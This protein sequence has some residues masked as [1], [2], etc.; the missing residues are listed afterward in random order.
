MY[1]SHPHESI[2]GLDGS[3]A[4]LDIAIEKN[5]DSRAQFL[6][7]DLDNPLPFDDNS[8]DAIVSINSLYP[9]GDPI[10]ALSEWKRV[11]TPEGTL[12]ISNPRETA[13]PLSLLAAHARSTGQQQSFTDASISEIIESLFDSND[14]QML[15]RV[16]YYDGLLR[17]NDQSFF[18]RT[19][20]LALLGKLFD[21]TRYTQTY[22]DHNH[23]ITCTA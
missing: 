22:G 19:S 13:E 21:V 4:M 1:Y 23:L 6:L 10:A 16:A 2:I 9:L 11:L 15:A 8:F 3:Q 18:S 7:H 17:V 14:A 12:T 20:I 5:S